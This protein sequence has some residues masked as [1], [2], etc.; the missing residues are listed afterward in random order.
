MLHDLNSAAGLLFLSE[1]PSRKIECNKVA[2]RIFGLAQPNRTCSGYCVAHLRQYL[3]WSR[4]ER[5][6]AFQVYLL[7]FTKLE[8][9][10]RSHSVG[11]LKY[12]YFRNVRIVG[13]ALECGSLHLS[14]WNWP[15]HC[16]LILCFNRAL[17]LNER[18]APIGGTYHD[19]INRLL[20]LTSEKFKCA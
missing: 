9:E 11:R 13:I 19:V 12:H 2:V 1:S 17:N 3:F 20:G 18:M 5:N 4:I 10:T 14:A 15:L 8:F 16:S 6:Q 7:L